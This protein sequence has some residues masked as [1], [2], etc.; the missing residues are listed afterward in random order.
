MS[1]QYEN[2]LAVKTRLLLHGDSAQI[3][4]KLFWDWCEVQ[5][6]VLTD[7]SRFDQGMI[8]KGTVYILPVS[9]G[10]NQEC[11]VFVY[12]LNAT[13]DRYLDVVF[14]PPFVLHVGVLLR[15]QTVLSAASCLNRRFKA[16]P[17]EIPRARCNSRTPVRSF[18]L[19]AIVLSAI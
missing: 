7:C 11:G 19:Q 9:T 6:E 5:W 2:K 4:W 14:M 16:A 17:N 1:A 18:I 10:P 13:S 3:L 15:A 8:L 12:C